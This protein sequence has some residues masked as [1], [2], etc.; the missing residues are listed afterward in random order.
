MA[1]VELSRATDASAQHPIAY[2]KD[3]LGWIPAERIFVA[4]PDSQA[5]ITLEQT[6][7]PAA[8]L[9]ASNYLL[10]RIPIRDTGAGQTLL[11]R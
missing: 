1:R 11:H 4:E 2:Q 3:I 9:T 5:T 7:A 8:A 10:A 6:A